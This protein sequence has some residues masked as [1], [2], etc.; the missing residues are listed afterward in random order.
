MK[1]DLPP[2]L[3]SGSASGLPSMATYLQAL[4]RDLPAWL[5]RAT[6]T[7]LDRL[8]R[9]RST[10]PVPTERAAL[11]ELWALAQDRRGVWL[12][13]LADAI[14]SSLDADMAPPTPV[15]APLV[16]EAGDSELTLTLL[17]DQS[18]D[19]DIAL[20]HL[21]QA[22][23]SRAEA[24]LRELAARCSRIRGLGSVSP[25]ANPMRPSAVAGAVH[26]AVADFGLSPA[27]RVTLLRELG[28]AIGSELVKEYAH[29]REL[30]VDWGVA[31]TRFSMPLSLADPRPIGSAAAPSV[32]RAPATVAADALR[33]LGLDDMQA[34][35]A[36]GS[37]PELMAQLLG[38]LLSRAPLTD[39]ARSLIRRI[40]EPARRIASQEPALWQ[41]PDHPLWLLLDRLV[42][43]GSVHDTL[44]PG[45][46]GDRTDRESPSTVG[47]ALEHAV[48]HLET[49]SQPDAAQ[50]EAA[51]EV[52]DFAIS[53]LLDQQADRVAPQAQALQQHLARG[54]LEDQLRHQIVQQVRDS[55][56][57]P[58]LRRFLVGPWAA[59]LACS[60]ARDGSDSAQVKRQAELVD[61]MIA[62]C[63]RP[64]GE[65]LPSAVFTRCITHARLGL[66]D[67]LI[68]PTRLEA[69]LAG[70]EQVLRHPWP[71]AGVAPA[72]AQE[73][74]PEPAP[75]AEPPPSIPF[76]A[77]EPLDPLAGLDLHEALPTVPIEMS[78]APGE[79]AAAR[80][81]DPGAA[82]ADGLEPGQV[83]R[84]FLLERWMNAQLV[85]RSDN[86]SMFVFNSR[87]GGRTHSLT[88]RSLD[89][90]RAAGLA[91]RIERGAFVAQALRE[92]A[93]G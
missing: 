27:Q 76:A 89:K 34:Q 67:A 87:H 81:A 78:P 8:D 75:P 66:G 92:L 31:P 2:E 37:G 80:A 24:A 91:T 85:W 9:L 86:R 69:E 43:A 88:R 5:A 59:A 35:A 20:S 41:S 39:S 84:L 58:A 25:E 1:Y 19:E 72:P 47:A 45:S 15:A 32:E 82:W 30:L 14:A 46:D 3:A 16:D 56:A 18:I 44:P 74:P 10:A 63:T 57:P 23:E 73:A 71:D 13:G 61:V 54:E 49:I 11:G 17:D 68:E 6:A 36:T 50:C 7:A 52:V 22:A 26:R 29:Q 77:T 51:L 60:A 65:R 64:Q 62:A 4:K 48:R 79:P 70:L 38:V 21:V 55:G 53:G 93:G 40:D 83:C 28:E 42:S 33:R 90:L 12:Q